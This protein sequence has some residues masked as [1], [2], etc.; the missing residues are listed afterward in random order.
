VCEFLNVVIDVW[1]PNPA[2]STGSRVLAN[3]MPFENHFESIPAGNLSKQ[4]TGTAFS[5]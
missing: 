2:S 4:A 3:E 1:V 5:W